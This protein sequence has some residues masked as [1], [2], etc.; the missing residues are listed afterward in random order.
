MVYIEPN[1]SNYFNQI[2]RHPDDNIYTRTLGR[3]QGTTNV[4]PRSHS[5]TVTSTLN[6]SNNKGGTVTMTTRERSLSGA[7]SAVPTSYE[8]VGSLIFKTEQAKLSFMN[9]LPHKHKLLQYSQKASLVRRPVSA[10]MMLS[11][12]QPMFGT[13]NTTH[14]SRDKYMDESYNTVT[15]SQGQDSPKNQNLVLTS[16]SNNGR[17][18]SNS[19]HG[20]RSSQLYQNTN[21]NDTAS[22]VG[23]NSRLQYQALL[24]KH[25]RLVKGPQDVYRE[26]ATTNQEIG[27]TLNS[28]NVAASRSVWRP[29]KSCD[30]T[31]YADHLIKKGHY[32]WIDLLS[33]TIDCC[34]LHLGDN[35][36]TTRF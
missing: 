26:S 5:M 23:F 17:S 25:T 28:Y 21:N 35:V 15:V 13:L 2:K 6:G 20:S 1:S 30:E 11:S 29:K 3:S 34:W 24:D 7:A 31:L 32:V 33:R 27:W 8:R 16:M 22:V 9:Q 18:R 19:S 10:P 12:S 14:N 36:F 4:R